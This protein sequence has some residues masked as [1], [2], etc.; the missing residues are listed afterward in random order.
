MRYRVVHTTRYRY[1]QPVTLCHNEAHL[2]PRSF[3]RQRCIA[4]HVSVTPAAALIHERTDFFGNAVTYFAVQEPHDTLIVTAT[5]SVE[6]TP[7]PPRAVDASLPWDTMTLRLAHNLTP[8]LIEARHFVLDSPMVLTSAALAAF[9]YS[10]F[11]AGQPL[12]EAVYDLSQRIHREF[13]YDPGF[14][15]VATPLSEV[16][17]LRRGV[18][19]D[20]AHL[21]IGCL[22]SLGLPARYVSGYLQSVAPP[23]QPRLIGAD[24]S[25]AWFAVFDPDVGWVDF[26]PTNDQNVS[27]QHITTAWG[28]DYSD[29]TPLKGVVFGGGAHTLEVAVDMEAEGTSNSRPVIAD[30]YPETRD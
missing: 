5:S 22:R 26:D 23:G 2:R 18:C 17:T 27:D 30:Q 1:S 11:S 6:L 8:A 10:S 13:V 4:S 12:L 20:F 9:A 16:L 7:A 14:S 24:T 25:H 28:R 29:V 21:A 3:G 15:T 19:Q